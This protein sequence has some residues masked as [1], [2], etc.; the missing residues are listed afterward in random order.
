AR[1]PA[2]APEPAP[3]EVTGAPPTSD[4]AP[5]VAERESFER[6]H[7]L[8]LARESGEALGAWNAYLRAYPRGRFAP[9]ARYN[10]ALTLIRLGRHDAARRALTPLAATPEGYRAAEAARLLEALGQE[11]T[12]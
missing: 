5:S 1:R 11:E 3:T 4:D 12:R 7:R 8:H 6:A 2:V 10:R 9:E